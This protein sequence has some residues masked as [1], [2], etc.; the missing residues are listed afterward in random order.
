MWKT[1]FLKLLNRKD[2]SG[3]RKIAVG[4]EFLLLK[5]KTVRQWQ[6]PD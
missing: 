1:Y 2:Y 3:V 4:L 6:T 5:K